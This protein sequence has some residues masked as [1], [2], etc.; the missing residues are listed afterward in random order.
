MDR[1]QIQKVSVKIAKDI[2]GL[3]STTAGCDAMRSADTPPTRAM[4]DR[5]AERHFMRLLPRKN[6]K[7]DP[8]PDKPDGMVDED[9]IPTLD[10]WTERTAEDL[11][12]LGDEVDQSLPVDLEF[13]PWH[14]EELISSG[15][16]PSCVG[17]VRRLPAHGTQFTQHLDYFGKVQSVFATTSSF[18]DITPL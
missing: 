14:E 18:A 2:A 7:S 10:S 3:K 16:N 1:C 5:R 4:L 11:W 13:A 17:C 15:K 9:D 8:I 12:V 6:S